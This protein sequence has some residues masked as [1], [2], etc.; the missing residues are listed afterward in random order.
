MSK[1]KIDFPKKIESLSSIQLSQLIALAVQEDLK[2][3]GD[4]TTQSLFQGIEQKSVKTARIVAKES[5]VICGLPV[6]EQV[7]HMIGGKN[8]Y[9]IEFYKMDG[10]KISRGEVAARISAVPSLL[11]VGERIALNFLGLMSGIATK[12]HELSAIL[13]GSG[14]RL[15]DTRKTIPGFRE[16]SKYAVSKGG[17]F[18]HRLG[19]NDMILIKEN[20]ISAVGSVSEAVRRARDTHPELVVEIEVENLEQVGEALDTSA[21]ILMLDNMNDEIVKKAVDMVADRK[22]L[23]VSGNVTPER[24][25][26]IATLGVDFVS[27]GALTHTVR[28]LDL[29][30]LIA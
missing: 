16:L 5:G 13:K 21:D 23:E 19:L 29:S 2:C 17:G 20:H 22:Y 28:P 14:V 1:P 27:M 10:E 25:K 26:S 12:A 9:K 24:L 11:T 4:V 15:L 6:V 7:Y 30:M 8:E 18:N 3:A